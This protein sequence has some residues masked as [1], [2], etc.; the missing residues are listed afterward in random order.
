MGRC[1]GADGPRSARQ[2]H[3][4]RPRSRADRPR[5]RVGPLALLGRVLARAPAPSGPPSRP[6]TRRARAGPRR[7]RR[8]STIGRRVYSSR[9]SRASAASVR[10]ARLDGPD[11]V[12]RV[13]EG[14]VHGRAGQRADLGD[15]ARGHVDG[16][17]PGMGDAAAARAP[18][19]CARGGGAPRRPPPR[20][21]RRV[22]G[23]GRRRP[24]GRRPSRR[25]FARR[26]WCGSSGASVRPSVMHSPP[27]QPISSITSGTGSVSTM[28]EE[29]TDEP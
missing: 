11:A 6:A 20:R 15:V 8:T 3:A 5:E 23:C 19:R 13:A 26:A 28:C 4:E 25:R 12:A 22:R 27:V 1:Q 17:A 10:P 18:G 29:V 16:A 2:M 24:A 14:V 7:R 21:P 9:R